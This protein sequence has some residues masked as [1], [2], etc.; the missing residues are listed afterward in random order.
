[1]PVRQTRVFVRSDEPQN[2]WAETLIGTVF[3]PLSK[4]FE[5][6][7]GWFWFSRYGAFANDDSEDCDIS[8]IPA[9][10]KR[11]GDERNIPFHRSMRFRFD[12]GGDR[13][14]AFEKRAA[15]LINGGGYRISDFRDYDFVGDTGR[16]RFLGVENRQ[17]GR[18]KQRAIL[19]TTFYWITSKLV[20][21][22]LVGPDDQG[23][24]RMEK[25]D[26]VG[27][28]P[29]GSTFQALLHL[30][31]NIT[32]TPT[33]VYVFHKESMNLSYGTFMSPPPEPPGRWDSVTANPIRY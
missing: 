29:R 4:E 20:I 25:N 27:Q 1:M 2:D 19:T 14:E 15:E 33:D 5:D 3:G 6:A 7:L 30:F 31:C 12:V 11:P 10:Y 32:A 18:A 21:D 8:S 17:P 22:A 24:F 23:R 28:N 26:D 16:N 13:R 9:E